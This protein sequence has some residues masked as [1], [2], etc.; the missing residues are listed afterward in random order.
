MEPFD[1]ALQ[2][3]AIWKQYFLKT[4]FSS[5]DGENDAIWKRWRH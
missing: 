2:R 4:L 1:N 5:V 3:E